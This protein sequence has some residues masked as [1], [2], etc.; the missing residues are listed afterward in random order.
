MRNPYWSEHHKERKVVHSWV[1]ISILWISLPLKCIFWV[2]NQVWNGH[3]LIKS[4]FKFDIFGIFWNTSLI[5]CGVYVLRNEFKSTSNKNL[6]LM[7]I[8]R[9]D[10]RNLMIWKYD[11]LRTYVRTLILY[12]YYT[13][14]HRIKNISKTI[15]VRYC[16]VLYVSK[17]VRTV[18][19]RSSISKHFDSDTTLYL[20][21]ILYRV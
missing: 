2:R 4:F 6:L 17:N 10:N 12:F 16:T 20:V 9:A 7:L 21:L 3:P 14:I 11:L 13:L 19:V 5:C 18:Y 1:F 15:M 8:L